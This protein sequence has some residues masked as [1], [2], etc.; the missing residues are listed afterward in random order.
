[1]VSGDLSALR[2]KWPP[3]GRDGRRS[4]LPGSGE[5]N[6]PGCE[7]GRC[8]KSNLSGDAIPLR[9]GVSLEL[10]VEVAGRTGNVN[11]SGNS[12]FPIFYPFNNAGRLGA[13]RTF[14]PF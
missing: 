2:W 12:A 5:A 9:K 6:H 13:F 4:K 3:C 11:A 10:L 14:N 7:P 1:M 8:G